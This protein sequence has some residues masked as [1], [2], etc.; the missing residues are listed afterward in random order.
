MLNKGY[1]SVWHL[2]Q[3]FDLLVSLI[4]L[5]GPLGS[6]SCGSEH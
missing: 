1:F 3:C 6:Q 4:V 5:S 2:Q